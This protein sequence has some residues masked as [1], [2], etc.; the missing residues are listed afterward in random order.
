M[1]ANRRRA[2]RTSALIAVAYAAL[3][4]LYIWL[5]DRL[6]YVLAGGDSE[7]VLRASVVKGWGFVA[8][9]GLGLF[10][11]VWR[12]LVRAT[13]IERTRRH[14]ADEWR[15]LFWLGPG[16]ALVLEDDT[17]VRANRRAGE[18]FRCPPD[19]LEGKRI[20]ELTAD[21][22]P[23]ADPSGEWFNQARR[24]DVVRFPWVC[25]RMDGTAFAAE[26]SLTVL[27][28]E[29]RTIIAWVRDVSHEKAAAEGL[30]EFAERLRLLVEGTP[31]FFF[32]VQEMDGS[33]TY[34]SPSVQ[35]ITGR[36]QAEWMGQHHWYA[37]AA[38]VNDEARAATARHLEGHFDGR[39]VTVEVGHADG[40]PVLLEVY[41]YGRYKDGA[42][43]G[44]QGIA[45]DVTRRTEMEHE[46]R[47]S[48][49]ALATLMSNLPGMAYR[50]RNDRDWSMEFVSDGAA[51]L[52][53]HTPEELTDPAP[54]AYG[55]LIHPADRDMV[56]DGVQVALSKRQP[57]QIVYRLVTA[58]GE[59]R[60]V[61]EKGRGV[62]G[63]DG[64]LRS[65]EGFVTD[66]TERRRAEEQVFFQASLLDQVRNAVV[67][68]DVHGTVTYWNRA[69]EEMTGWRVSEVTGR[70]LADV[71]LP[72]SS[73]RLARRVVATV[74]RRGF[75]E[76]EVEVARKG[77]A[78]FPVHVLG[79]LIRDRRGT[80]QGFVAVATDVT[81]RRR[82]ERVRSALHRIAEA[83][84]S[85]TR[86]DEL[87]PEIHA[88]VAGLM[89]AK[90]FYIA[91]W[92][93]GHNELSFPYFVDERDPQPERTAFGRGLTE[94]V[95]RTGEPLLAS[96]EVFEDL[97]RRGEVESLGSPSI[98]WLGVPL[99]V[100]DH[101]LGVLVVQTYVDGVRYTEDDKG[102]LRFVSAQVATAIERTRA[103]QALR[104]SE[105]RFR[106]LA[107]TTT[108]GIL[109]LQEG[110]IVYANPMAEQISGYSRR[111]LVRTGLSDYVHPDHRDMVEQRALAR[112]RG[113]DVPTQYEFKVVTRSGEERW[114]H[115]SAGRLQL[116]RGPAIVATF[117]DIT[118][119]R[120]AEDALR[121][122]ELRTRALLEATPDMI[123]QLDRDGRFLDYKAARTDDLVAAP[124]TFIGRRLDEVLPATV[125]EATREMLFEALSTGSVQ[126]FE[127]GL[128]I[129]GRGQQ[130]F[131]A[132]IVPS[133]ESEVL[134]I[135]RN[136][137]DQHRLESQLRQSQKMEAVGR[138]AGGVAHDFNNLLQAVLSTYE[139]VRRRVDE[140]A[141]SAAALDELG[142][143]IRRGT[144]ITRQLLL[145]ARRTVSAMESCELN[146]IVSDA[147][148]LL[149][150]L[151][152]EN[153]RFELDLG[154]DPLP[155]RADR[156]QIEQVLVNLVVNACDAMP[157][158]GELSIT[159]RND[160]GRAVLQ[161]RDSGTGIGAEVIPR[162]FEPFFTTKGAGRGTGLGL[163]VVQGIVTDHG[164]RVDVE[165]LPGEGAT[166]TVSLPLRRPDAAAAH[167][168][169][170]SGGVT[171]LGDGQRVLLVE[172]ESAVR[173]SV[174]Q[175]LEML[176]YVV[177][178]TD[179]AEQ[180]EEVGDA[181]DIDLLLTDLMLP[182]MQGD[183][184][185]RRIRSRRPELPV[186]V[187]SGYAQ[188]AALMER[189]NGE[190]TRFLQKP[191]DIET[192]ARALRASL[193]AEERPH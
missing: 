51:E 25:R 172:D 26:V 131:E 103:E 34:V 111:Q 155:V 130:R 141:A 132:R 179:S 56:W 69:A 187:M 16:G 128:D 161:V 89:P 159:T 31:Q 115:A 136:V 72:R 105:L 107:E 97:V 144:A 49:R 190:R 124:G 68:T 71:A 3:C 185:V 145:F 60:W 13:E 152:R 134:A 181:G 154:D 86:L 62:F 77:A 85:A 157:D 95:V 55:D 100:H 20:G 45:H 164:G 123:F 58:T 64:A 174:Q 180:A 96:P 23:G 125:A 76:G 168:S 93:A 156:G 109:I 82:D 117:F 53:G 17:V 150:R 57:F 24:G 166:F 12:L 83:A 4:G 114:V 171:A 90:N 30:A 148:S 6:V 15:A 121:R 147:G 101:T 61:W 84:N 42:L 78:V 14:Q 189:I 133:G 176:G 143:H 11:L 88:I 29:E 2:L 169:S 10:L 8:V 7:L 192:L 193:R 173:E 65:L 170:S 191:F 112:L 19:T 142:A 138:L 98:D 158:G 41:E 54:P 40:Y 66:I 178:S 183:E 116:Q 182:G 28:G 48:Q 80:P 70:G 118:E 129:A 36:G 175:S 102:L 50:C 184:L 94:Y 99:K 162:I 73:W 120:L 177:V 37:T 186:I 139:V 165:T 149:R 146:V 75:W 126:Q 52:T 113:E 163:A 35:A 46:L 127:Y 44:L 137:T 87:L 108:A 110:K 21:P 81:E 43:V 167:A 1:G 32:Y 38:A 119:R 140:T 74:R 79:G 106:T 9:T 151:V 91:L 22:A 104:E 39:P 188:E 47:E 160:D 27:T 59:E 63:E 135:V 67:A 153:I 92:D 5:S 18:L 33:I 122:G